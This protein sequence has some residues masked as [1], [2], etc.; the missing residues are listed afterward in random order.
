[1]FGRF[2][3][4]SLFFVSFL[5]G[6]VWGDQQKITRRAQGN[7]NTGALTGICV[8]FP[9]F[10]DAVPEASDFCTCDEMIQ[11][12]IES[13]CADAADLAAQAQAVQPDIP[14]AAG[15]TIPPNATGVQC[16]EDLS[17]NISFTDD[18]Q[19]VHVSACGTYANA[20]VNQTGD[21]KLCAEVE[22]VPNFQD[23][24]ISECISVT[25]GGKECTCTVCNG[26][27]GIDFDCTMHEA[28]VGT[29]GCQE[30][31]MSDINSLQ[32]LITGE[33][34]AAVTAAASDSGLVVSD[35][36]AGATPGDD[37]ATDAEPEVTNAEG[38]SA[39]ISG[40]TF[41][42][43]SVLALSSLMALATFF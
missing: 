20:T 36:T 38:T 31:S 7:N 41:K 39:S 37:A 18:Q 17:A 6:L 33:T 5:S 12:Y 22:A 27:Y 14:S 1:M 30:Y 2:V 16:A 25:I 40:F 29:D 26:G 23:P 11:C 15:L 13:S 42:S 8:F 35:T 32:S 28:G 4:S 21:N 19:R 24:T 43:I 10:T 3:A 34:M 9:I